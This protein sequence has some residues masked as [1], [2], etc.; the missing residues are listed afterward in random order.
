M[1]CVLSSTCLAHCFPQSTSGATID[2][3]DK[4]STKCTVTGTPEQVK[5]AVEM[6]NAIIAPAGGTSETVSVGEKVGA[7]IGKKG[8]NIQMIQTQSGAKVDVSRETNQVTISG[9]SAQVAKAKELVQAILAGGPVGPPPEAEKRIETSSAGAVIGKGGQTIRKIQDESGARV[10][11]S[12]DS[13]GPDV[14]TISGSKAAVEKAAK[15]VDAVLNPTYDVKEFMDVGIK[16]VP[17]IVGTKGAT[18][19][20]L[21]RDSGAKIDIQGGATVVGIFGVSMPESCAFYTS[22]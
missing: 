10:D 4:P 18:I 5:K 17:V 22:F 19:Q 2:M 3:A 21:Q 11:I 13:S 1:L 9:D 16:G 15:M 8:A 7:V 14:I 6:I 20:S 12:K